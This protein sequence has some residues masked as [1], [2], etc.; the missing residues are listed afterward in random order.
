MKARTE[1]LL[2]LLLWSFEK[3]ARPTFRN[4]TDSYESW[5]F[6]NGL[7]RTIRY[8]HKQ[9]LVERDHSKPDD[10][11]YR[12]TAKGRLHAL[13]GR[14]PQNEWARH[15]DGEWRMLLFDL[16]VPQNTERARLRRYLKNRG[17]GY[18]QNSVWITPDDLEKERQILG[19]GK[20]N[21]ESLIL[22][23]ARPCAGETDA[24][25]VAGAWDFDII[26]ER[27]RRHLKLLDERP[28]SK[29]NNNDA[30]KALLR[31]ASAEREAWVNAV[32]KDPLL[33]ERLL[34]TRY[35]GKEAWRKRMQILSEA[36][37]Q[38]FTFTA[39]N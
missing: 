15:W 29:L 8:L 17:M 4:L 16:P 18:L 32:T 3:L 22:L 10:R 24:E 13:G 20:I 12:L 11:M 9:E 38:L 36:N 26:N 34:P 35:L 5:A 2:N 27:Y 23:K 30:S 19:Q 31:W 1:E 33:P 37:D 14:D 21:V 28:H 39:G 25:I 7:L 6:R